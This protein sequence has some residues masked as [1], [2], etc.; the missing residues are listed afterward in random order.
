[1]SEARYVVGDVFAELAK[2]PDGS[3]DLITT[4]PPFLAL[5]SY[6]PAD[7]PDKAREIGSEATPAVF[8]STLLALTR[9][10]R[11]V[12]AP[13]G[14]IAVELGDTYSGNERGSDVAVWTQ[15]S[16]AGRFP[17]AMAK[18][19]RS[20]GWPLNKSLC[21]IPTLYAWSLA[22]GRNLLDPADVIDPWRIR[23]V[24]VWHRPN[25]P[26]GA[27]GDKVRPSTSYITVATV[28]AN[29]WFDLDAERSEHRNTDTRH[30]RADH[31]LNGRDDGYRNSP[32]NPA[33][34]PPLDCWFDE[35]DGDDV[36]TIPTQPYAGAHY[37]CVD[38]QTEALTPHGWRRHDQLRDGDL[39]AAWSDDTQ[40]WR[41]ERATFHRYPYSGDLVAIDKRVTS[42]RLTPNHRVVYSTR[43]DATPRIRRADELVPG[44]R[45][46]L[47]APMDDGGVGP[48]EKAAALAGWFCTEGGYRNGWP[49]IHQ[50]ITAN[51]DKVDAIRSLLDG[52][53]ADYREHVRDRSVW[54]RPNKLAMF[55]V[56]GALAEWLRQFHK[57]LPMSAIFGW[58]TVDARAL[59]DAM[60]DGDGNRRA[61]G[62]WSFIQKSKPVAEAFQMLALRLGYRTT[63]TQRSTDIWTVFGSPG[64]WVDLRA[65]LNGSES[66]IGTEHY[67]GTVWCPSVPTGMWVARRN[68]QP[69]VTGNTWP[70]RLASRLVNLMCP[71]QVCTVCGVPR[72]RLVEASYEPMT[73]GGQ[74]RQRET[75][76]RQDPTR[77]NAQPRAIA[78]NGVSGGPQAMS[79]GRAVK[80]TTTLGWSDCGHDSWRNGIV[81]DPFAG[82]GTTL[83]AASGLGR[84]SIGIDLDPRNLELARARV[85]MFLTEGAA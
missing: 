56:R 23:N 26:V 43:K 20:T 66:A 2:I 52:I 38:D 27:L 13:H 42:Q 73:A 14:S 50:S 17:G 24:V 72:R 3:V 58:S 54:G 75:D 34:A 32:H 29:R 12:L 71:R 65:G 48:G 67:D 5:R 39:I 33:G 46:P 80:T 28:A 47:A 11:R 40:T 69:F 83:A 70:I 49:L 53:G 68:G 44:D 64:R 8:L 81:L 31:K 85:G 4:S 62:R 41:F 16:N 45:V 82:S 61:D 78:G 25:P 6:L 59:L 22:Y 19:D 18:R 84:D 7:H 55:E 35:V 79:M 60:I 37:A 76:S 51:P 9:E 15:H 21:G 57:H 77:T 1:M 10:W 74:P 63:L 36:W 30:L